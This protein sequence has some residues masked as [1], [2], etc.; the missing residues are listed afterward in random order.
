M[1]PDEFPQDTAHAHLLPWGEFFARDDGVRWNHHLV[2]LETN[3]DDLIAQ[4]HKSD[5]YRLVAAFDDHENSISQFL[6]VVEEMH[7]FGIVIHN[8]SFL[9][10]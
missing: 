3:L 1:I 8:C 5:A 2:L 4:V 6:I 9:D 7:W 10:L